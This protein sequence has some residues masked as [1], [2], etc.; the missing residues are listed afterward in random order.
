MYT[1]VAQNPPGMLDQGSQKEDNCCYNAACWIFQITSW[2]TLITSIIIVANNGNPAIFASFG[3]SYLVYIILEF[4][5]PTS[6]YLCNKTSDQGIY[7]K[8]GQHFRTPPTIAFHCE[9]YHY[10]TVRHTRTNSEGKTETYTTTERRTTYTETY[11]MPYYSERDVSGLFYLNCD[12]AFVEKKH[13]IK[14]ELK[15][16]INFADAISIYDYEESKAAFWRRNRFRDVHFDFRESRTIPGM[17]HHNLVKL[18][19][20][21]PCMVNYFWFFLGTVFMFAE[22]L[23]MYIDSCCVYQKFKVRKLVST[24]YDLNQPV[25]QVFVPQMNL[26]TQQ[27]EYGQEYY[28]YVNP[29]YDLQLPTQEELEAA[30]KYQNRVPDY[31]VSS[32]EG[33]IQQGVIMDNPGYSSYNPNEAPAEFAAVSGNVAL[34]QDQIVANG[35]PP[36]NYNQPG[37]QFNIA[38]QEQGPTPTQQTAGYSS[39]QQGY[40]Q[41]GYNQQ[42]YNPPDQQG[43]SSNG[44]Q[45][46]Y[47]PN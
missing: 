25:Y 2:A 23:R 37:F 10:E 45:G 18:T 33:Q 46:Y 17:K 6:K 16:E 5:S 11:S 20:E 3:V 39:D 40:N 1:P 29:S 26:I 30:K 9:C 32:G 15:E 4:C 21:E 44:Q 41:Q 27:F 7:Q 34:A 31:Q 35:G 43:Y 8:M 28:N 22:F 14:L 13:Y 36:A 24:R 19:T 42:G 12:R 47:P 38:P